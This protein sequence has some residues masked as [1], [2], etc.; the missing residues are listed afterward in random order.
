MHAALIAA[1]GYT[2][3]T[4]LVVFGAENATVDRSTHS[5]FAA[6]VSALG[7]I[8]AY[9]N[10]VLLGGTMC[11]VAT[12][13]QIQFA[14]LVSQSIPVPA[15]MVTPVLIVGAALVL[16][17]RWS[18]LLALMSIALSWP[19]I[20]RTPALASS[21]MT[22]TA[23]YWLVLHAL[24]TMVAWTLISLSLK[25]L[26]VM[27][28]DLQAQD[29]DLRETIRVA[30]DGILVVTAEQQVVIA[31]PAAA[32][33]LGMAEDACEGRALGALLAAADVTTPA[34]PDVLTLDTP[35]PRIEW[36]TSRRSG[37]P[38]HLE[39]VWRRMEA[40]RRQLTL[41]DV[42]TR[43]HSDAARRT[44]ESQVA[45]AQRL[46][47]IGQLAAGIAHDFNNILTVV[48]G[49][50]EL[51]QRGGPV[52]APELASEILGAH[53]RGTAL[54]QQL[55]SFARRESAQPVLLDLSA[56]LN[57][58]ERFLQRVAGEQVRIVQNCG[59]SCII[60]I[61]VG[62]FEQAMLNLVANARDAMCE[63][64]EC[65]IAVERVER[66]DAAPMVSVRVSDTGIGMD[67]DTMERAFD[68]F[69]TTKTRGRGTGLGLAALHGTVL[70]SGGTV[71][72]ES[73]PACGTTVTMLFPAAQL[74]HRVPDGVALGEAQGPA[75]DSGLI[76][77]VEDD[78]GTRQVAGRML[79]DLGYDVLLA[80]SGDEA[81]TLAREHRA[82]LTLLLTDVMMPGMLGPDVARRM[83]ELLP[84]LPVLFMSG[85]PGEALSAVPGLQLET[86]FMVKP[87]NRDTLARLTRG[88]INA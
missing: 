18:L 25:A 63:G 12:F 57:G 31:N 9:Y 88:K 48:G 59:T 39:L 68:P 41:Q 27:L 80:S 65:H 4:A 67:A 66:S 58:L 21:G 35:A 51:I 44:I 29:A 56:H 54:T 79:A 47:S 33:I 60:R 40:G 71:S 50:A 74:P 19:L 6:A 75:T 13:W 36:T 86:D 70:A 82:A 16:G 53:A 49:C 42:S 72:L 10:R 55:L 76:L 11:I 81:L 61:D 73:A 52:P 83:H 14:Y 30:P 62:Q 5:L 24:V 22:D 15:M 87:F 3:M 7:A 32:R 17:S 20:L 84:E 85:Y 8:A 69:F 26:A 45:H 34:P 46:E 38:L 1:V 2:A 78:D 28:A 64:G 43:V 23:V 77:V 37:A